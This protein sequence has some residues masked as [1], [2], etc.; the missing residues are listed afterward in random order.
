MIFQ[1][2]SFFNIFT[3]WK[4]TSKTTK[5]AKLAPFDSWMTFYVWFVV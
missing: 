1:M 3:K 5:R 2:K 4:T